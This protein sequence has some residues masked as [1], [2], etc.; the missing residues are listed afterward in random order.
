MKIKKGDKVIVISGKDRGRKG[1]V[2]GVYPKSDR[3]I[4]KGLNVYKKHMKKSDAYPKGG[5]VEVNR[6]LNISK[7][8]LICPSCKERTRIGFSQDAKGKKQ[9]I[10]KKCKKVIN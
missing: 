5:I 4:I 8:M 7:V 2:E 9:R 10:C 6:P 1:E 3:V